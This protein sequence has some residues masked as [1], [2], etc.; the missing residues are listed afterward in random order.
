MRFARVTSY[1]HE[2]GDW[3]RARRAP[4]VR[5]SG[6]LLDRELLG[7]QHSRAQFASWLEPPRGGRDRVTVM[8]DLDGRLDA[9]GEPLPDAWIGGLADRPTI[10]GFGETYGSI[11]LKLNPLGAYTLTGL[12]LSELTGAC[13]PLD[14][15]FGI[16]GRELVAGIRETED[17]DERF[18][19]VEAF[20]V[21]RMYRTP[22]APAPDPAVAWA[23]ERMRASHG[24]VRVEALA[25]EIGCSSRYLRDGF[26]R[27][28]G[29]PP[30]TVGRLLRFHAVRERVA[31]GRAG[32]G[33]WAE[34]ARA[35]GY[36]DQSH[37]NREFRELAGTTP[38]DFVRRLIPEGGVIG[39]RSH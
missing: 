20:L 36:A 31:R 19:L 24:G 25:R 4:D 5:L 10:V 38:G 33:S 29:L 7:Y 28:V 17:W 1:R 32:S 18:D 22:R 39:D 35:T 16:A 27:Q 15:V 14:D 2:L 21:R 26:V 37:L 34:I 12:P 23:W 6:L 9:D 13:V 8:I 11:D 3:M 30:K